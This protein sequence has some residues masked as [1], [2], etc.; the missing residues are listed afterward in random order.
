MVKVSLQH[1]VKMQSWEYGYGCIKYYLGVGKGWLIEDKTQPFC[2]GKV[3][4][5]PFCT[6]L[7]QSQRRSGSYVERNIP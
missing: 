2:P 6:R 5:L 7:Y 4:R 1:A 3:P